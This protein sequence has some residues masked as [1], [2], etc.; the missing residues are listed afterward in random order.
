MSIPPPAGYAKSHQPLSVTQC[1]APEQFRTQDFRP[2]YASPEEG[3]RSEYRVVLLT[4]K[5]WVWK[6]DSRDDHVATM[7]YSL[8]SINV[9]YVQS[10]LDTSLGKFSA[11]RDFQVTMEQ[12]ACIRISP[13]FVRLIGFVDGSNR[14]LD[15]LDT[16]YCGGD[17]PINSPFIWKDSVSVMLLGLLGA[18]VYSDGSVTARRL[19]ISFLAGDAPTQTQIGNNEL[20]LKF[21]KSENKITSG[22]VFVHRLWVLDGLQ[23]QYEE[24]ASEKKHLRSRLEADSRTR[25]RCQPH[26]SDAVNLYMA[27]PS[28]I[29]DERMERER[30]HEALEAALAYG[31]SALTSVLGF[32]NPE[33][34]HSSFAGAVHDIV[35]GGNRGYGTPEFDSVP[36]WDPMTGLGTPKF[37][38]QYCGPRFLVNHISRSFDVVRKQCTLTTHQEMENLFQLNKFDNSVRCT[39]PRELS[40]SICVKPNGLECTGE[41]ADRSLAILTSNNSTVVARRKRELCQSPT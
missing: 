20:C 37:E 8:P 36:G 24:T 30:G 14:W 12:C 22:K 27:V 39:L 15:S 41:L 34:Y 32:I 23:V 18:P 1:R 4:C 3:P 21:W 35:T 5:F 33:L 31:M 7:E 38:L 9:S 2:E 16:S 10:D 29:Y 26:Q 13:P 25:S 40:A 6:S 17:D 28:M 19:E 11:D